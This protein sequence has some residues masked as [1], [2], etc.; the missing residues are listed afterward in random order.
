MHGVQNRPVSLTVPVLQGSQLVDASSRHSLFA[1][2]N[3]TQV[4]DTMHWK[5]VPQ[6]LLLQPNERDPTLYT[7]LRGPDPPVSIAVSRTNQ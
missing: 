4:V 6:G 7:V 1:E 2:S 3:A 5:P